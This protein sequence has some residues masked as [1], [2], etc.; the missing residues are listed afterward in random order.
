ML[1]NK[2]YK[3]GS[4]Y[5][6]ITKAVSEHLITQE[7]GLWAHEVRLESNEQRHADEQYQLP[8]PQEAQVCIDFTLALGEFLFV[9]P[10]RVT[11]GREHSKNEG[12]PKELPIEEQQTNGNGGYVKIALK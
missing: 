11:R 3:D 2:G 6:R 7:M 4:L 10:N 8:I 12:N 5:S 1:K 9:L